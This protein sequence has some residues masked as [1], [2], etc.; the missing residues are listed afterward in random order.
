ML[1]PMYRVPVR[2]TPTTTDYMKGIT[3]I[4]GM[5]TY[6]HGTLRL[7]CKPESYILPGKLSTVEFQLADLFEVQ[8][9]KKWSNSTLGIQPRRMSLLDGIPGAHTDALV[10]RVKRKDR[11]AAAN[12]ASKVNLD[13]SEWR[14]GQLDG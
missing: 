5:L 13:L 3:D 4:V 8:F 12:L 10:L 9:S 6:E 7:E 2:I 1:D 11:N 14:L